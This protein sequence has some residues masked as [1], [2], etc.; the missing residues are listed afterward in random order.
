MSTESSEH[1]SVAREIAAPPDT[2]WSLISDVTRMG[3]WSPE[4]T[5]CRWKGDATGPAV[6]A[7][8]VGAN[9]NESKK[10]ETK[11]T[12]TE[13]DPG[14]RFAFRVS[15]GPVTVADWSYRIEPT[16]TGSHV[17][18]SWTDERNWLSKKLGGLASGVKDRAPHNRR[19]MEQTLEN[20]AHAA[21]SS[22]TA[23]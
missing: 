5:S 13:C 15:V 19:T 14:R 3:E 17:T 12:V 10:W 22:T 18:E 6:E 2:V 7:V 16:D 21:E 4:T 8:F 20:L 1:V 11:C 9:R 23:P